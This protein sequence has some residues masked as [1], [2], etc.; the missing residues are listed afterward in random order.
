MANIA[1]WSQRTATGR[2]LRAKPAVRFN[3]RRMLA[4]GLN[5]LVW[6]GVVEIVIQLSKHAR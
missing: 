6:V 5:T 4:L 2:A 3:W 1:A